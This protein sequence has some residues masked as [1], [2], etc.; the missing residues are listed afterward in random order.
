MPDQ[1]R[2]EDFGLEVKPPKVAGPKPEDFGLEVLP[3]KTINEAHPKM[4]IIQQGVVENLTANQPALKVGYL[5][6]QGFEAKE[7]PNGEVAVRMPGEA[8]W[9]KTKKADEPGMKGI[10]QGL[11]RL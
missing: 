5:Q 10:L 1:P 7:L 3:E 2:P 9:Y 6:K 8:D 4:G 11:W